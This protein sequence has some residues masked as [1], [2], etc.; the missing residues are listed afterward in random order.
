MLSIQFTR[1]RISMMLCLLVVQ[2]RITSNKHA[3]HI[4][5]RLQSVYRILRQ[6][7]LTFPEAV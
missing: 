6:A 7:L 2:L 3:Y 4:Y 1:K 5:I